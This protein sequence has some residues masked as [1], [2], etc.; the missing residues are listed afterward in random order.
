MC[1]CVY[2][3]VSYHISVYL[4]LY[5]STHTVFCHIH[6]FSYYVKQGL[7]Q[8]QNIKMHFENTGI[9]EKQFVPL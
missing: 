7:K 8:Y 2:C 1:A 4:Y 6:I 9:P 5:V 3:W